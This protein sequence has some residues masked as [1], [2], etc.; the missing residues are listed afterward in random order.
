MLH[1]QLQQKIWYEVADKYANLLDLDDSLPRSDR[2]R[3][4]AIIYGPWP[5][6]AGTASESDSLL[7][8]PGQPAAKR[9]RD[10]AVQD[11]PV[12]SELRPEPVPRIDNDLGRE[13]ETM[14]RLT[15]AVYEWIVREN[16]A[17][18]GGNGLPEDAPLM[19]LSS[20][21]DLR[22][23]ETIVG[24]PRAGAEAAIAHTQMGLARAFADASGGP[25]THECLFRLA[26]RHLKPGSYSSGADGTSVMVSY[27]EYF[28]RHT[29]WIHVIASSG[30]EIDSE[31]LL[32]MYRETFSL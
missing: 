6:P 21:I 2:R 11:S 24:K 8:D 26:I 30:Y 27:L 28:M 15:A 9:Y 17:V 31:R 18:Y 4:A 7:E 14:I 22:M 12:T 23:I 10:E 32:A 3:G 1:D 13:P 16:T 20:V 5:T 29:P 19:R 25:L